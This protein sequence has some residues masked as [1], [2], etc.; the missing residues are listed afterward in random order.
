LVNL[1]E[2]FFT[3]EDT[4]RK[5]KIQVEKPVAGYRMAACRE[6]NRQ[7]NPPLPAACQGDLINWKRF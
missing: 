3:G 6:G 7:G 4:A 2:S 1:E 5:K